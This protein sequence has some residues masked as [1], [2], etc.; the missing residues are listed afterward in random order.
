MGQIAEEYS[1]VVIV[2]DDNP[3]TE[4]PEVIVQNILAG[5]KD[6]SKV[7]VIHDRR[8]AIERAIEMAQPG[9]FVLIAG[10]GHETT[11]TLKDR[12]IE[13]NDF[14]VAD[15]IVARRVSAKR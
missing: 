2:T 12:T 3:R 5:I 15:E 14:A 8:Q 11:Q 1:D 13:F 9:D 6:R 7:E 4:D 10:K